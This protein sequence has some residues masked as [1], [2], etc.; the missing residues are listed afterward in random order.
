MTAAVGFPT[1]RLIRISIAHITLNGLEP[2]EWR[3]LTPEELDPLLIS[4]NN[5]TS[6]QGPRTVQT[7][8]KPKKEES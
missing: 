8:K 6:N 4:L 3:D 7:H 1:L 5:R 2:G